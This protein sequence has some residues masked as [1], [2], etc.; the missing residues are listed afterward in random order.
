MQVFLLFAF[1]QWERRVG[2]LE[3]R[4]R[5]RDIEL[6]AATGGHT[7]PRCVEGPLLKCALLVEEGLCALCSAKT[8]VIRSD[9]CQKSNLDVPEIG[10][11]GA[12]FGSGSFSAPA[13]AA[14]QVDFPARV[15]AGGPG[16]GDAW[17]DFET[18]GFARAELTPFEPAGDASLRSEGPKRPTTR[19]TRFVQACLSDSHIVIA[20]CSAPNKVIQCLVVEQCPPPHF[21]CCRYEAVCVRA[22]EPCG[23]S[24]E[25]GFVVWSDCTPGQQSAESD[26]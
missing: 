24:A 22:S 3:K 18:G 20:G 17:R 9:F 8:E 21:G 11:R 26:C 16:I 2:F 1:T 7:S 25:R 23:C 10:L 4:F 13:Q 5:S 12:D 19:R 14:K 6:T 15:E